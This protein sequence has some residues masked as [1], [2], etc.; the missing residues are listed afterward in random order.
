MISASGMCFFNF[1]GFVC[2]M[3]NLWTVILIGLFFLSWLL[4]FCCILLYMENQMATMILYYS[5]QFPS[6]K[7]LINY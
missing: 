2:L 4:I 3:A 1:F 6:K 5:L 7:L